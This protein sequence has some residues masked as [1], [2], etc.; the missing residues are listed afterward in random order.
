ML[1]LILV[2]FSL[3]A[4]PEDSVLELARKIAAALGPREAVALTV[5]NASSL[6]A[7]EVAGV[8]REIESQLRARGF[9]LASDAPAT[10]A[11]T[12]AENWQGGVWIAE[13]RHGDKREV[14][15][16]APTRPRERAAATPMGIDRQ[17]ILEQPDPILDA[18][19]LESLLV[20][21]EPTEVVFYERKEARWERRQAI[22]LPQRVWP[23]DLR[24]RLAIEG[25]SFEAFLPGL[26]CKGKVQPE[27][28]LQCE[29]SDAP[30]PIGAPLKKGSNTFEAEKLPPFYSTARVGE[31]S[32]AAGVDGRTQWFD[33]AT[34][35]TGSFG[36]WGSDIA[37]VETGCG[38]GRQVL[39]TRPSDANETDAVQAYEIAG[40][41]PVGVSPALE[42]SGPVTAMWASGPAS[43]VAITRDLKTGQYAA[44]RI[45]LT[46]SR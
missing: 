24:G 14:V 46:C 8:R 32:L 12:L 28:A 16:V 42:F 35:A 5:R 43:V 38:G 11:V 18:V 19:A 21:L 37:A 22:A 1:R 31:Y 9:T 25:D 39:A 23:R 17:L 30:W 36:G 29:E 33:N 10:V 41:Q 45:S 7:A 40:R 3:L 26:A 27:P 6:A 2:L 4:P 34:A 13:I 44:F 20:V 15:M